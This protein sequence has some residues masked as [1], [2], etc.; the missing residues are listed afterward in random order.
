MWLIYHQLLVPHAQF[1]SFGPDSTAQKIQDLPKKGRIGFKA[2]KRGP[3]EEERKTL[4]FYNLSIGCKKSVPKK[5]SSET[6]EKKTIQ[7]CS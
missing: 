4:Y 6:N 5:F 2:H 7:F 1:F 3:C